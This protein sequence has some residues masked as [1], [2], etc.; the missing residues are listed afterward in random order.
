MHCDRAP[1]HANA[2]GREP[3]DRLAAPYQTESERRCA[4]GAIGPERSLVTVTA[5]P[6]ATTTGVAAVIRA[7]WS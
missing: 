3:E 5:A 4:Y 6:V 7:W 1:T 2:K